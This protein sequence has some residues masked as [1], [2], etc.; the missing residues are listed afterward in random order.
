MGLCHRDL[1]GSSGVEF[2]LVHPGD[3][4]RGALFRIKSGVVAEWRITDTGEG[5]ADS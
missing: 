3:A 1:E 2:N 4:L 5:G